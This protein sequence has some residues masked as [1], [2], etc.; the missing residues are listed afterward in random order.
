M[1]KTVF[2]LIIS[3]AQAS[4]LIGTGDET[5]ETWK[6]PIGIP[7]PSFGIE[8][9]YRMY[10]EESARNPALVYKESGSGGYYTHYVDRTADG[11]TNSNNPYGSIAKPR[12]TIPMNPPAGSVIEVHG[13][14]DDNHAGK[15]KIHG[16]G[17][18]DL[19]IFIRGVDDPE[20]EV[21][22]LIGYNYDT[23]YVIVEGIKG[24]YIQVVGIYNGS[25]NHNHISIRDCDLHSLSAGNTQNSA[26]INYVVF[27]N[28][29]VHDGGN[30]T[31]Y[32][33][34]AD[35]G[36][37]GISSRSSYVWVVDN[38][39][40]HNQ[41][42]AVQVYAYPQNQPPSAEIT[43]H[44]IYIGRNTAFE[45]QQSAFWSK[46]ARDV[47]FSQ[48]IAYNHQQDTTYGVKN[49]GFGSQ[50]D[51][52]R[53]WFLFN[54]SYNNHYGFRFAADQLRLRDELYII[55]NL[56]YNC[57]GRASSG[58]E[59]YGDG[60][61]NNGASGTNIKPT[62]MLNTFYNCA[63]GISN[64]Y[65]I[66]QTSFNAF[67]NIFANCNNTYA[68][69]DL[70]GRVIGNRYVWLQQGQTASKC[71]FDYNL[72]YNSGGIRWDR[73]YANLSAF[74]F[75]T[76]EGDNCIVGDP[77]FVEPENGNF[78][79]RP[80]SPINNMETSDKTQEIFDRFL[81]LYGIDL[82]EDIE[83]IER[84]A[85]PP[86][87]PDTGD[88]SNTSS[89]VSTTP[90]AAEAQ[91]AVS[92][93]GQINDPGLSESISATPNTQQEQTA[94]SK[95]EDSGSST[96]IKSTQKKQEEE[97]SKSDTGDSKKKTIRVLKGR[98]IRMR[99]IFEKSEQ[100]YHWEGSGKS[101][102]EELFE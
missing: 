35:E 51:P 62:I 4:T 13:S 100:L 30:W 47:I 69:D 54:T 101:N 63:N 6:P 80:E 25:Y 24:N 55:G 68:N 86:A 44:H 94:V 27:Y 65:H 59:G 31:D 93:N 52:Q 72:L 37:I 89:S 73:T 43:P 12:R 22:I 75:G 40:Y 76:D 78:S 23:S 28:N 82:A 1:M 32:Q 102:Q 95:T 29:E 79:L 77:L 96:D 9:T 84:T 91:T 34:D 16:S 17:T 15:C 3:I 92:D 42:C 61:Y 20:I 46:T 60:I 48:N 87:V 56:I 57:Y 50:Y 71:E 33:H 53:V 99:R 36:G 11:A 45:N 81:Q 41:M 58:V 97:T 38:L 18:S 2:I 5:S 21:G 8:E 88:T 85:A 64:A 70:S 49:S 90:D 10:D 14:A 67:N 7:V 98:K 19:P 26:T 66:N 39:I 74:Q 83:G